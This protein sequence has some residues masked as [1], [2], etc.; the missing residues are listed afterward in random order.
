M[1]QLPREC[2]YCGA[3]MYHYGSCNCVDARL[4]GIDY[5]RACLRDK[6]RELDKREMELL[7]LKTE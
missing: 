2:Q 4:A 3:R 5:E 1:V 6:L 7:G